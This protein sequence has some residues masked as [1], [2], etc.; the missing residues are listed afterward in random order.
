MLGRKNYEQDEIDRARAAVERQLIAYR[1]LAGAVSDPSALEDFDEPFFA[2]LMLALDR[3]FVHR[4]R[5]AT[6]KDTNALN[7]VELI[8][9]ALINNVGVFRGA[10]VIKYVPEQSVVGLRPGDR[11]SLTADQFERLADAF[12]TELDRKFR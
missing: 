12:F 11:V 1:K 7:E 4:L 6:G 8:V 5:T 9:D 10:S 3:P 2:T